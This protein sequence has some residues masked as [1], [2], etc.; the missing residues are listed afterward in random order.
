MRRQFNSLATI[1]A[2]QFLVLSLLIQ[3]PCAGQ[4]QFKISKVSKDKLPSGIKIQGKI[5]EAIQW[6]DKSG[7]HLLVLSETGKYENIRIKH[8]KDGLDAELFAHHYLLRNK[9]ALQ[10]WKVYDIISDCPVDIELAFIENTLQLSDLNKDG[11]AEIWLMYK[12]ACHG[13]V[14][15]AEL[16][17]VMYQ[18]KKKYVMRGQ[19]KVLTGVDDQGNQMYE[20]GSFSFDQAFK[21][22]LPKF[23]E[24]AKKLWQKNIQG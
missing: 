15:P 10:V 11:I 19:T 4:S 23:R 20:G 3:L 13:D 14:S 8:D 9:G 17:V 7:R 24:F 21:K 5:K 16:Y 12:R 18:Q 1:L 6:N 2:S 22:A